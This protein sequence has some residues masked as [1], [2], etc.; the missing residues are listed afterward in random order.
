M[1]TEELDLE[2]GFALNIKNIYEGRS[3]EIPFK[4]WQDSAHTIPEN[5]PAAL[6]REFSVSASVT[7]NPKLMS[8]KASTGNITVVTN[9]LTVICLDKTVASL[10]TQNLM[11]G[12]REYYYELSSSISGGKSR[13]DGT[14]VIAVKFSSI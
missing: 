12:G 1:A 5:W 11:T 10:I 8:L 9:T 3:F 14:G 13:V 7:G 2:T 4:R 6:D